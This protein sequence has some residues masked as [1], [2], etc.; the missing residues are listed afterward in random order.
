VQ[1]LS[2]VEFALFVAMHFS[3]GFVLAALALSAAATPVN[4]G[5]SL[6]IPLTKRSGVTNADG[7]INVNFLSVQLASTIA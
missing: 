3:V 6:K 2:I 4:S 1:N 7:T 5:R